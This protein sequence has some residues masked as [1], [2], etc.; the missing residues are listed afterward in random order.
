MKLHEYLLKNSI[1]FKNHLHRH[2]SVVS[3]HLAEGLH[4]PLAQL[5]MDGVTVSVRKNK[6]IWC[7]EK[8]AN[9][10]QDAFDL[11]DDFAK[12]VR[13]LVAEQLDSQ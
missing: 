12:K 9:C 11:V 3:T 6:S 1:E 7:D 13:N 8:H 10:V 2:K 5:E 4:V